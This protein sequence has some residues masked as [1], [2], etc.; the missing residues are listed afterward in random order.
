[1]LTTL[2]ESR[3]GLVAV[4][5][6][7]LISAVAFFAL[8]RGVIKSSKEK[9]IVEALTE[10]RGLYP[11]FYCAIMLVATVVLFFSSGFLYSTVLLPMI[12]LF[13]CRNLDLSRRPHVALLYGTLAVMVINN[14]IQVM[15]FRDVLITL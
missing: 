4:A 13:L 12:A 5:L 3:L 6:Y 11:A 10:D 7:L 15:K 8:L 2:Q 9:G 14:A 1:L